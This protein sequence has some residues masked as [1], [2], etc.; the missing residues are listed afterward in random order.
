MLFGTIW[1][2]KRKPMLSSLKTYVFVDKTHSDGKNSKFSL[3]VSQIALTFATIPLGKEFPP[4]VESTF[5]CKAFTKIIPTQKIA[6]FLQ[7]WNNG[8]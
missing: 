8:Q 1:F 3:A 6:N 7:Q 4:T 2:G 5:Y